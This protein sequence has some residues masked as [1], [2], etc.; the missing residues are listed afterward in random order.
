MTRSLRGIVRQRVRLVN[1]SPFLSSNIL[2][3]NYFFY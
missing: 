3:Y 1:V 2:I